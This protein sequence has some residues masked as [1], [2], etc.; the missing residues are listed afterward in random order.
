MP[1]TCLL[2]GGRECVLLASS[3]KGRA[4]TVI[5]VKLLFIHIKKQEL[6]SYCVRYTGWLVRDLEM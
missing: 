3:S 2:G 1:T 6:S 5:W 4:S